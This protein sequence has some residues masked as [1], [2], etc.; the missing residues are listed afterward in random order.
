MGAREPIPGIEAVRPDDQLLDAYSETVASTVEMARDA[1]VFISVQGKQQSGS[2]SGFVFTPDGYVLTNS[3]VVRGAMAV[4]VSRLDGTRTEAQLV[5]EDMDTDLAVLRIGAS[6]FLPHLELGDSAKL[7]VGQI[8]IAI[9]S[10]LGFTHSVTS[11]IVSALGRSLRSASGRMMDNIIQTDA[12]LNPGNSGGPLLDSRGRVM[13]VNTAIIRGAQALSFAVAVNSAKW[14]VPQLLAH[15]RV[16]RAFIGVSGATVPVSR[17]VS[18]FLGTE[19]G[20]AVR[21]SEV[22][23]GS[24]AANGGLRVDDLVVGIDGFPV[25]SVDDLQRL[26]DASRIGKHCVVRVLRGAQQLYLNVVPVEGIRP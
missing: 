15:G 9:G 1:V 23:P 26:L 10:P 7:R 14:V 25:L 18:R 8:A 3:H 21:L 17:R 11:G 16:R 2:G 4:E 13:G 19:Q 24:P 20:S 5:G 12:A 22:Q 6:R